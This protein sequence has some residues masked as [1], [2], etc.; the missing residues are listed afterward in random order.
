MLHPCGGGH[1]RPGRERGK[2]FP[3]EESRLQKAQNQEQAGFLTE[4]ISLMLDGGK[5]AQEVF[6]FLLPDWHSI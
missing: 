6:N 3:Y 5:T 4:E 2:Q 1:I